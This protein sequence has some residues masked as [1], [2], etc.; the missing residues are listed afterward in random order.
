M[1]SEQNLL[2][3]F[4]NASAIERISGQFNKE[5]KVKKF[6]FVLMLITILSGV[7]SA[8]TVFTG[9]CFPG[10]PD[11]VD[12]S[13]LLFNFG[14]Q[15]G[16]L[17]VC[18]S[19]SNPFDNGVPMSLAG[20]LKHLFVTGKYVDGGSSP[21]TWNVQVQVFLNG[22]ATSLTCT[23][24]LSG[25]TSTPKTIS[26]SDTVDIVAV[27]LGDVISVKMSTSGL[28]CNGNSCPELSLNVS[29]KET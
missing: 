27:I 11:N 15:R 6:L 17:P 29:F 1:D 26:C 23:A 25:G 21:A 8:Q 2:T 5:L 22:V 19:G 16:V 18:W 24:V 3:I 20:T 14:N 10:T 4:E 12:T 7:T 13:A 9:S 28:T